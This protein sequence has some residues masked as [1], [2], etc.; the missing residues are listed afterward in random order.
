MTVITRFAPSPTGHLH[1]GGARTAIFCWLLSKHCGGK[2]L[3]RI[4]DTD[5]ERSKQEY[6]DS[7]LAS[8]HWLGLD[9]DEPPIYQTSR[10]ARYKEAMEQMVASGHAYWCSCSPDEVEA[11]REKARA[12]GA[13][14]RYDGRCRDLGLGP[15][16]GRAVRLRTPFSGPIT[17][18]DIVKGDITVDASELDDMIIWRSDDTPT[19]NFAVVVDDMDMG[20]TH[21]IRGDDHVSNTHKQILIFEALG[22]PLPVFGHVPMIL[23]PDKQKLS[24]RH[25]AKAAVEYE[26][27]GLLP[28][29]LI[30]YLVRLGWS[31]G[32]QELFTIQ[33][34]IDAFDGN[35]MNRAA[36]SFDPEKLLWVNAHHMRNTPVAE[37]AALTRPFLDED[38]KDVDASRLEAAVGLYQQRANTLVELA[39]EV[40]AILL[41]AAALEYA[42]GAKEKALTAESRPHLAALRDIFAAV[43]PWTE[44][45]AHDALHAYVE[46]NGL[47]F[48]AVGPVV[49][50]AILASLGGPGLPETMAVLGKDETLARMD[51]L[52]VQPV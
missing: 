40:R 1:I 9:P 22:H 19:Y 8:M 32:D 37:L 18:H 49:R 28:A 52:L 12:E 33:E 46:S 17:L 34:L 6:T 51:R 45:G 11:M 39:K 14:P 10:M 31:H 7:I 5:R 21:V 13:K 44:Q 20:I 43:A 25:G 4:E 36:A 42:A 27:D 35:N 26:K 24:K 48:K 41:P 23:G 50:V 47:K 2:F 30:N 3:L 16:P 38:L 29:A 15:G